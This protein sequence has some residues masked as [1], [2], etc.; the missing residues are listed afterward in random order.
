MAVI[1][2]NCTLTYHGRPHPWPR[3]SHGVPRAPVLPTM[4]R[5]PKP[6]FAKENLNLR[7]WVLRA[8]P[9][10][11]P[12]EPGDELTDGIRTWVV[13]TADLHVLPGY[14]TVDYI[15]VTATLNPPEVP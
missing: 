11:W 9:S 2:A 1:L 4:V 14:P 5:G 6:G 3:D 8:D 7:A 13:V 12:M 15:G 10:F